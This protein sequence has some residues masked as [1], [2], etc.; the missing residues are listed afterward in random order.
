MAGEV[1][2]LEISFYFDVD[3]EGNIIDSVAV[4]GNFSDGGNAGDRTFRHEV[5]LDSWE[6]PLNADIIQWKYGT[7]VYKENPDDKEF[8]EAKPPS[9]EDFFEPKIEAPEDEKEV[10]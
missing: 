3:E 8:N 6:I 4:E 1:K 10:K 5:V 2:P 9:I 7:F